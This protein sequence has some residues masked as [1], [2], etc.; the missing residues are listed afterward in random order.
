MRHV[1]SGM[2]AERG[3]RK[4]SETCHTTAIA[5]G[6]LSRLNPTLTCCKPRAAALA[7]LPFSA[8]PFLRSAGGCSQRS[9][10]PPRTLGRST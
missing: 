5:L 3:G 9:A 1:S 2:R 6:M 7:V 10:A 4:P 8:E